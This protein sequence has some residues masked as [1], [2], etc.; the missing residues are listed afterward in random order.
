MF[1]PEV[2]P[3][4]MVRHPKFGNGK[5]TARYGEDKNSKVIVKFQEEGEKKLALQFAQLEVDMPEPEPA[6]LEGEGAE[7][8]ATPAAE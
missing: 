4:V 1:L 7:A 5:V 6:L 2:K 8:P 3:S